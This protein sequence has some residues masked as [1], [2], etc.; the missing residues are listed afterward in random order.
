V[1]DSP[2]SDARNLQPFIHH[3]QTTPASLF[4]VEEATHSTWRFMPQ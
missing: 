1:V 2:G 4:L 3:G